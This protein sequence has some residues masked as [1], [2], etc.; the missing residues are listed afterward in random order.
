MTTA[1]REGGRRAGSTRTATRASRVSVTALTGG[2]SAII[3]GI[4]AFTGGWTRRWTS[5]DGLIVLRTVRNLL[6]GNGPVFNAGERVEANTS[7]LW[8]YLIYLVA[9]VTDARL[10][11]I[12]MWLALI[13]TTI[14]LIA[15]AWGTTLLHRRH[16]ALVLLPVGGLVYLALPPA[17]D[18]ATSGL[19]W[20]LSVCWI[21]VMWLLLMMW[22]QPARPVG[23]HHAGSDRDLIVYGVAAGAGLSWLV[24][25][26]LALYGGLV[27]LLL[28]FAARS[29]RVR[30]LILAAALPIPAAYQIFRM[31][32]YGLITP[33]TAVAKS[34]GDA[35][36]AEGWDYLRDLADPYHLWVALALVLAVAA[37]MLWRLSVTPVAPVSRAPEEPARSPLRTPAAGMVLILLAG[38]LHLLYVLRVG[39]DFM[40]GRMLLLPIFALLLPLAVVPVIDLAHSRRI[41]DVLLG[42]GVVAVSWWGI[43]TVIDGHELDWETEYEGDLGIVDERDFWAYATFREQGDPPLVAADFRSAL[44]MNDYVDTATRTVDED[45]ALMYQFRLDQ[46]SYSWGVSPRPAEPPAEDPSGLSQLPPTVYHLNLGMTS[47]NAPLELRVLD[48]V[49]LTTPLAA[50]Q[51]RDPDARVGHDKWLPFD[52]QAADTATALEDL[53]PWYDSD[54]VAKARQALQTPEMAEL[55]ATYRAPM[56]MSRFLD[57]LVFSLTAGRTLEFSLDADEV[58]EDFGPTDPAT[59]VAWPM[60]INAEPRR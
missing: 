5:D 52:W 21:A 25:P 48:T 19:E 31:G 42:A 4:L 47:M 15:A 28:L 50:R 2:I 9:L 36:W 59:P 29:W 34:A 11:I 58:I 37:V 30:G 23:R 22:A 14:A 41:F 60:N 18:F 3:L 53:P 17:R 35:Q 10:E 40:H 1:V 7:T 49:G 45:A 38:T 8:Q 13:L 43:A 33:H 57:N 12:A 6:A 24:R 44:A 46:E 55:F 20:G 32:Y 39:G 27:G 54:A 26:E 16:R 56:T 51:P